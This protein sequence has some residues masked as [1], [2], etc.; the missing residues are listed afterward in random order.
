MLSVNL[1]ISLQQ[2]NE[3]KQSGRQKLHCTNKLCGLHKINTEKENTA[4][5]ELVYAEKLHRIMDTNCEVHITLKM[6]KKKEV[7]ILK[8][9]A[10]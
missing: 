1:H 8:S 3:E 9:T 4:L 6:L 7:A 5:R 2:N 10:F